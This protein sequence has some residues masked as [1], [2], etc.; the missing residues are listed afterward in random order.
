MRCHSQLNDNDISEHLK[1]K[2][3]P[4]NGILF[5]ELKLF[6]VFILF[7]LPVAYCAEFSVGVSPNTVEV[8]DAEPGEQKIVKFSIFTVSEEPLLIYLEKESGSFD[9]FGRGFTEFMPQFSEERIDPWIDFLNNPVEID[10]SGNRTADRSWKDVSMLLNIPKNAEP[11]YHVFNVIPR[12]TIYGEPN[13]PI[14]TTIVTISKISII[15]RVKG[16]AERSGMILDTTAHSYTGNDMLLKT[17][18][19]NTGSVTIY[20]RAKNTV[21]DENGTLVGEF[22]SPRDYVK[23]HTT[24]TFETPVR[25][26]ISEGAY[27]V[28]TT[29][30]FTTDSATKDSSIQLVKTT[31]AAAPPADDLMPIAILIISIVIIIIAVWWFRAKRI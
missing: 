26:K 10:T 22:L 27:R 21:Y 9:F 3:L 8:G 2:A 15:F 13:A 30:D 4:E 18:F 23:P 14:G 19:Q 20:T 5:F 25:Q 6:V 24:Y 28:V 17:F 12:P 31:V 7:L 29:V 16:N 11:G 1:R